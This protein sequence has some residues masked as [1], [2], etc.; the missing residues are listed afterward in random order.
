MRL[1]VI[2]PVL[3]MI[4]GLIGVLMLGWLYEGPRRL[5]VGLKG[6]KI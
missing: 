6:G 4:I 2:I 3:A 1:L 5:I